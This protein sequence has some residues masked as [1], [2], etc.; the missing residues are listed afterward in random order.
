MLGIRIFI[1]TNGAIPVI[2]FFNLENLFTKHCWIVSFSIT[3]GSLFSPAEF[4]YL[5]ILLDGKYL[6]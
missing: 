5:F 1:Q 4:I 2:V 3:K 6:I